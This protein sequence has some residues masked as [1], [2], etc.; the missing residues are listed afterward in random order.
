VNRLK[1]LVEVQHDTLM[2]LKDLLQRKELIT[3]KEL[4]QTIQERLIKKC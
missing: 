1:D 3:H 2:S 4:S